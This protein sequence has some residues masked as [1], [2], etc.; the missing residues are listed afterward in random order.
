MHEKIKFHLV[1]EKGFL[2][3]KKTTLVSPIDG[4]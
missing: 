2:L 4:S 1:V 3:F